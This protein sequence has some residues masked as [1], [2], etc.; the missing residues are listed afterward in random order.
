MISCFIDDNCHY[1]YFSDVI[2]S[3]ITVADVR[4]SRSIASSDNY[5]KTLL[6]QTVRNG[7]DGSDATINH[8][9]Y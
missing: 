5:S 8:P 7:K 3:P 6:R 1:F 4:A 9:G 2:K